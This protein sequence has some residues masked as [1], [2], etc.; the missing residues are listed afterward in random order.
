M[1]SERERDMA[2]LIELRKYLFDE[3]ERKKNQLMGIEMAIECLQN[4]ARMEEVQA[5]RDRA[6]LEHG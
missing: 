4:A 5:N 3:M 6:E 1:A 2:K